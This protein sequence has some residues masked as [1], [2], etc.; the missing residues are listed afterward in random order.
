LENE[1]SKVEETKALNISGVISSKSNGKVSEIGQNFTVKLP[2]QIMR[3][4]K[5]W[6]EGKIYTC[7]NIVE[8]DGLES[9]IYVDDNWIS[10][11][12]TMVV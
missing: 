5:F 3:D 8:F 6:K 2:T 10:D 9:E 7:T 1:N 4:S 11:S 12:F